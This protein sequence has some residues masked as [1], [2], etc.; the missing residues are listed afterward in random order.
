MDS[1]LVVRVRYMDAQNILY[2]RTLHVYQILITEHIYSTFSYYIAAEDFHIPRL[3]QVQ[4]CESLRSAPCTPHATRSWTQVAGTGHE[5]THGS[6]RKPEK[7]P[8]ILGE[9]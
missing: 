2:R 9:V 4:Q 3:S 7:L 5:W 6:T 8:L 1:Q